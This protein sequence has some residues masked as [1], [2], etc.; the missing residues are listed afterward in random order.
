MAWRKIAGYAFLSSLVILAGCMAATHEIS[1][2]YQAQLE[3]L[4]RDLTDNPFS[5]HV[6]ENSPRLAFVDM[7]TRSISVNAAWTNV[8]MSQNSNLMRAVLA[9]EIAHV[10]LGHYNVRYELGEVIAKLLQDLE[11]EADRG[12]IEILRARGFNPRDYLQMMR[13]FK[14][15]EDKNPRGAAEQYYSSHPYAGDR[16]ERAEKIIAVLPPLGKSSGR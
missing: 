14:A 15:I 11:L 12:A 8:L 2:P 6:I 16:I 3:T 5:I 7:R 10:Q 13:F 4:V 9:H 1:S